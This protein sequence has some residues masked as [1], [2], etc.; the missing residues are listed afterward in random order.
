[1]SSLRLNGHL[2]GSVY[3]ADVSPEG[4]RVEYSCKPAQLT[5]THGRQYVQRKGTWLDVA[6]NTAYFYV[7]LVLL[8]GS[9][10]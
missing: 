1:M 9:R 4:E 6:L 2:P 10:F 8:T 5:S 7:Q 3:D